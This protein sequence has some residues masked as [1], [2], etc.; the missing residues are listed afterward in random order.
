MQ[1]RDFLEERRGLENYLADLSTG[2]ISIRNYEFKGGSVS[3]IKQ[4]HPLDKRHRGEYAYHI[5]RNL[6]LNGLKLK[7]NE[8]RIYIYLFLEI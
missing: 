6:V 8:N 1:P 3:E 7:N 5:V 4:N 2:T